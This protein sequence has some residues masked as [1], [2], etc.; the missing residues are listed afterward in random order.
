M[1]KDILISIKFFVKNQCGFRK[2]Y[3]AQYCLLLMI[4]KM[5]EALD[6]NKVCPAV[7]TDL[8]KAFD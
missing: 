2:G 4:E 6:K 7:F 1:T 3:N 8:S 5:K